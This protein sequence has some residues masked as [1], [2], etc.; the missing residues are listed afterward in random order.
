MRMGRPRL[1]I[2]AR[3]ITRDTAD[4]STYW[5]LDPRGNLVPVDG[6]IAPIR[7]VPALPRAITPPPPAT[8]DPDPDP[9]TPPPRTTIPAPLPWDDDGEWDLFFV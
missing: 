8:P 2:P 6:E 7:F 1:H 3:Y 4:G 5:E 9:A